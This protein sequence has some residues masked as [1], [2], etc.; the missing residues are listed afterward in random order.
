MVAKS[1][2][3][4]E[5]L[6]LRQCDASHLTF[7]SLAQNCH[8]VASLNIAGVTYLTDEI[9]DN[10]AR[11]MPLLKDIDVSWNSSLTDDG[12]CSLLECCLKLNRAV[13]CGLKRITSQPFLGIIGDLGRWRL[14]EE[15]WRY[16]R[17]S[18]SDS[19]PRGKVALK[20]CDSVGEYLAE[21]FDILPVQVVQGGGTVPAITQITI[22]W[23]STVMYFMGS[24]LH[25][26]NT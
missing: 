13:F 6:S 20:A 5:H 18:H 12:I 14:L 26:F 15:L 17:R 10:L 25:P 21:K 2:S 22:H 23:L 16:S 3:C 9:L 8:F 24:D 19:P 4:L 1:C 7:I 11:N